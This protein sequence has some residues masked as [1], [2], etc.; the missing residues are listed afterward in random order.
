M[1][2]DN[3]EAP[4]LEAMAALLP[5]YE[6][7]AFIAKGGMG[8]VYKAQQRRLD[9]DV[10]IKIL[11][12]ELGEDAAFVAS[13]E[14]EA[15]AMAKLNH[16]NLIGVYDYGE[17]DGMPYIVMEYVNGKS[18]FYS[19]Q[20]LKVDPGQ[21]VGI[22]KG[23]CDGLA[24]A[25]ENGVIH[26]DI[27]PANILLT[28]RAVPKIGDFGL[29][30]P[31]D[32][33][34]AGLVM[35]TPG[36]VAPEVLH[37]PEQADRRSDLFALGVVLYELLIG[38]C[39]PYEGIIPPSKLAGCDTTLD[40]I[41]EKA[42]NPVA[43]LRY[44]TAEEMS[45]DLE[46]WLRRP[47]SPLGQPLP[48]A[49]P[50]QAPGG[51]RRNVPATSDYLSSPAPRRTATRASS[52]SAGAVKGLVMLAIAIVIGAVVWS[53]VNAIKKAN[54][55]IKRAVSEVEK[56]FTP[57]EDRV[58]P[59][60]RDTKRSTSADPAKREDK[61]EKK[62]PAPIVR[63]ESPL[64]ALSRLQRRLVSGERGEMP[65][66]SVALG[67]THFM[68]VPAPMSWGAA[69]TFAAEHGAHLFVAKTEE[70]LG[71]LQ[72]LM[73]AA[74]GGAEAGLWIGAGSSGEDLWS[75]V[76]G[77]PWQETL[78]PE[79]EGPYV[80]LDSKGGLQAREPGDR[81][82]FAIQWRADGTNP[83]A[84]EE[85]L[86]R[87][88]ESI[89]AGVPVYPPGTLQ[90][91]GGRIYIAS[92]PGSYTVAS[93]LAESAGGRLMSLPTEEASLWLNEHLPGDSDD[94]FWLGGTRDEEAWSWASGEDWG[95][96]RWT[97]D[98]QDGQPGGRLKLMPGAGWVNVYPAARSSGFV[99]QWPSKPVKAKPS[100]A[101]V[102]V[103]MK[104]PP[105]LADLETKAKDL[106]AN[107]GKDRDKELAANAKT[108]HWDLDTW[109]N[110][111]SKNEVSAWKRDVNL[112]KQSV[113][114]NRVPAKIP[115]DG[116]FRMSDQMR[117]VVSYCADKQAAID[118][119]FNAKAARIRD[120]Y[121]TRVKAAA[122]TATPELK[123]TLERRITVAGD[124]EKWVATLGVQGEKASALASGGGGLKVLVGVW[125]WQAKDLFT[126][127]DDGTLTRRNG[128]NPG[129]WKLK[130]SD[131][132]GSHFDLTWDEDW[133]IEATVAPDG[134]TLEGKNPTG[135]VVRGLKIPPAT[136][137]GGEDK[138]IGAWAFDNGQ[139]IY[140]FNADGTA[141]TLRDQGTWKLESDGD[142]QR[143]YAIKWV[144][145][146]TVDRLIMGEDTNKLAGENT[147]GG[148][149]SG[150][151]LL[152][153]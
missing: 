39:P 94:G 73:P 90:H 3:F 126:F 2:L 97:D 66:G 106:L 31:V 102:I 130:S 62:K 117:K 100:A 139:A 120:S 104:L 83:A 85:V 124:L 74:E 119:S 11:P 65:Y 69:S 53:K 150:K 56:A 51:P 42:M 49:L 131:D 52:S 146:A 132:S 125:V 34:G 105:D 47:F 30:R 93:G 81:Y 152:P 109:L 1:S 76:D 136:V 24:H 68:V 59:A 41:C 40:R 18:L 128:G 10:A 46:A 26:R 142:G 8:A 9:R 149:L 110:D 60:E 5:A 134:Q 87:T 80:I 14:T 50:Q 123:P 147:E 98:T 63:E 95:Y 32:S 55:D 38:R 72:L 29:A 28:P 21:A 48:A 91:S 101:P 79:G 15:K 133:T 45:A 84:L 35:G 44:Q 86:K 114:N 16:P 108:F 43:D 82:P 113:R 121:V 19:A 112:L 137:A 92:V 145:W 103:D 33:D 4:T 13:F 75:W 36:Y 143:T 141:A 153:E 20:N 67:D 99:I 61:P 64:K 54:A 116:S 144:N 70:D 88:G 151:R 129:T 89:S 27:K 71:K 118:A 115:G 58:I 77:T 107:L 25:H 22:V 57:S 148:K 12:R 127:R 37:H 140:I 111:L 6:F 122:E 7:E 23:I 135:E 17:V 96:T 138:F 78:K